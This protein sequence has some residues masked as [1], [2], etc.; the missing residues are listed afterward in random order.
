M[1]RCAAG[2]L[3]RLLPAT[4]ILERSDEDNNLIVRYK[5]VATV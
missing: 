2:N 5:A 4:A 1:R 3:Y